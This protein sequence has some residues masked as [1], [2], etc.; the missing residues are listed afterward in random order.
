LPVEVFRI[1]SDKR[2]SEPLRELRTW[3][4]GEIVQANQWL[5]ALDEAEEKE[6]E[7]MKREAKRR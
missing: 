7:K 1:W 4:Y 2:V 6:Y 5:D 3:S